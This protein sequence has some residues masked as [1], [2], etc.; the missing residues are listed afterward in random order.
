MVEIPPLNALRSFEYAARCNGFVHAG[1]ELGV[2]SAAVSLQVKNLETFLGKELFLRQGNRIVLTDAG[3]AIY[4]RIAQALNQLTSAT[5][6]FQSNTRGE[7]FVIS[8]MPTLSELWLVPKLEKIHDLIDGSL[9]I[10]VETDPVDLAKSNVDLRLTY[11]TRYYKDH[12]K[13]E[14]F[15]DLAV[16]ACS[17][18][19][20]SR[21]E[22]PDVSLENIPWCHLIHHKWGPAFGSEPTWDEWF[23][24]NNLSSLTNT[25]RGLTFNSTSLAIAAARR[26]LGIVLAPKSLIVEDLEQGHL[27]VP[28]YQEVQMQYSYFA[29]SLHAKG[30]SARVKKVMKALY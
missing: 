11:G 2:S 17:G 20:W 14:L 28:S 15:R 23:E 3:E 8:V 19:F 13:T 25:G 30:E 26:S 5:Q 7:E 1:K 4:P 27:I 29:I 10:R 18:E 9:E 21:F 22:A 16:P 24:G 12:L 6:F